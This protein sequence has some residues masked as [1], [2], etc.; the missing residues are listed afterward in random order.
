MALIMA[1]IHSILMMGVLALT[2]DYFS[3]VPE[4]YAHIIEYIRMPVYFGVVGVSILWAVGNALFGCILGVASGSVWDGIKLAVI[5][6][7][8]NSIGRLWP[9]ILTFAGG[10]FLNHAEPWIVVIT[11]IGGVACLGLSLFMRFVRS[12][13]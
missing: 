6:G 5:I 1:V 10:A 11:A 13:F 7:S 12:G 9:Y 8:A 3:N 4:D 2:Y